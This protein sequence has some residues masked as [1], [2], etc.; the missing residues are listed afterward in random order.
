M[1]IFLHSNTM[2]SP[3]LLLPRASNCSC[4]LVV[5]ATLAVPPLSFQDLM[6]DYAELENNFIIDPSVDTKI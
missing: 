5:A 4:D 6:S 3:V 2:G 1:R